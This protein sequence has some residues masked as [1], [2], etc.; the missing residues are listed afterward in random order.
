MNQ[1]EIIIGIIGGSGLDDPKILEKPITKIINTP[2]GKPSDKLTI[3]KISNKKVVILPRHNKKH[4]LNPTNVPYQAN[5]WAL[6]QAGCTHILATTACGSLKE[7]F[8]PGELVFPD[9]FIDFTKLRN[10]T[11]FHNKVIHTA[12]AQPF[13][14]KLRQ[15]LAQTAKQLKIKYHASGTIVT[16]E[17]PRFSTIAE[18]K[19]FQLLGADLINMSTVPEVILA[20]ELA[21]PY[22]SIA[23]VTDYDCWKKGEVPVSFEMILERMKENSEKVKKLL[24]EVVKAI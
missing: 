24:T 18:S 4:T 2:Y 20:A 11:F 12:M 19:M 9:Q 8:T 21:I 10:L 16:I 6:K 13:D 3:G 23:M 17:G 7:E 22:Q 15:K 1:Q 5:I 14:E